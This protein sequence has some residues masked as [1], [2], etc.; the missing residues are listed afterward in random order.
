MSEAD[1]VDIHVMSSLRGGFP[2]IV[3]GVSFDSKGFVE[4]SAIIIFKGDLLL[5]FAM[6][7]DCFFGPAFKIP[8][9]LDGGI[10]GI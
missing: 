10:I 9:V 5:P 4:S 7:F 2:P 8:G 3:I 6:L 1:S